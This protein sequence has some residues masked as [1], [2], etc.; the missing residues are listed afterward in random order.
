VVLNVYC[1][2]W[3]R[4]RRFD[5]NESLIFFLSKSSAWFSKMIDNTWLD[6]AYK[7]GENFSQRREIPRSPNPHMLLQT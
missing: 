2:E 1:D 5:K 4:I 6:G 7:R 3:D